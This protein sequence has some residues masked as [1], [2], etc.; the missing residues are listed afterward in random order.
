M[1][2]GVYDFNKV[3]E[4]KIFCDLSEEK[5]EEIAEK[6]EYVDYFDP[7]E[8]AYNMFCDFLGEFP[9]TNHKELASNFKGYNN[10]FENSNDEI[11]FCDC[12]NH[13]CKYYNSNA[14]INS[15]NDSKCGYFGE[16]VRLLDCFSEIMYDLVLCIELGGKSAINDL[17]NNVKV[18]KDLLNWAII[19]Y[20][21]KKGLME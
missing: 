14:K 17:R 21:T 19:N 8:R 2:C 20:H 6:L 7:Y 1:C 5:R 12:S 15:V 18:D 16:R 13:N 9:V 3:S 4:Y 11:D 10:Y